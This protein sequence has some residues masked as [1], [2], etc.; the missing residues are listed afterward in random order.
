MAIRLLVT[1]EDDAPILPFTEPV[2]VS[3]LLN[4]EGMETLVDPLGVVD[5]AGLQSYLMLA[6]NP[7]ADEYELFISEPPVLLDED[8]WTATK[9]WE[10]D[11]GSVCSFLGGTQ[12]LPNGNTSAVHSMAG[13]ISE[14][15]PAGELVRTFSAGTLQGS[16][17]PVGYAKFRPTLEGPPTNNW[18]E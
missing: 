3:T 7:L 1:M 16:F 18:P 6:T 11:L 15:N 14:V 13:T 12:R 8:A 10:Y 5:R 4:T 2:V 9:T 17:S